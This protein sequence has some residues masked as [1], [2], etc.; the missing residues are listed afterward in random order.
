MKILKISALSIIAII[1][2]SC[3]ASQ[4]T[5]PPSDGS[6]PSLLDVTNILA[7]T[8]SM[9]YAYSDSTNGNI[10]G[11]MVLTSVW[12]QHQPNVESAYLLDSTNLE[13]ILKSGLHA[14]YSLDETDA[15]SLSL[16]RG[17]RGGGGR[18]SA[19]GMPSAHIITNKNVLIYVP[20]YA[21][22]YGSNLQLLQPE[23]KVLQNSDL[24]LNVAVL[25]GSD[26]SFN[27]IAT[28]G[29]YGLVIIDSHGQQGDFQTGTSFVINYPGGPRP[30]TEAD[31]KAIFDAVDPNLYDECVNGLFDIG[32]SAPL[33]AKV[34]NYWLH[35]DNS[36]NDV[37]IWATSKYI[38]TLP[39]MP[40]T[41]IF[42]NMC[43][44][45]S[46]IYSIS[47]LAR[48]V[49]VPWY[50]ST[51]LD[52]EIF[53][54]RTQIF[55]PIAPA[56]EHTSPICYYCWAA[57]DGNTA[58]VDNRTAIPVE[59]SLVTYLVK[60]LDSTGSANLKKADG[61]RFF[62]PY[63]SRWLLNV[64]TDILYL[65][66]L[67]APNYS[68]NDSILDTRDGQSYKIVPIGTQTWM[69]QNLNYNAPG[70]M[71]YDNDPRNGA[72]LGRLYPWYVAMGGAPSDSSNP[73][74]V[75]GVCPKGWHVPSLS[76]W[77]QLF[78][79]TGGITSFSKSGNALESPFRDTSAGGWLPST[80]N[81]TPSNSSGFSA[82]PGGGFF[83]DTTS[84]PLGT[85]TFHFVG[86][87][88]QG[89]FLTSTLVP[90]G[91]VWAGRVNAITFGINGTVSVIQRQ[92]NPDDPIDPYQP[93]MN[94]SCRC[95]KDP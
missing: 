54:A 12:A 6:T 58:S 18:L 64:N 37:L 23:L 21:A 41:V 70:S 16:T 91:Q 24:G 92:G 19:L 40:N 49:I 68:Y 71:C 51:K 39:P 65:Q 35:Y 47:T 61:T 59:D 26:A 56:F 25:K 32:R 10:W 55:D 57:D 62:D 94:A 31:L 2:A 4:P 67:G 60:T 66:C 80:I 17:G 13:I 78:T 8:D 81:F 3:K 46:S 9:F 15:D 36:F 1:F 7:G 27:K 28:F 83:W 30:K 84:P 45:G 74:K 77:N 52:T 75:Q 53:P 95:V 76:E 48:T 93:S 42:G 88:Q 20:P 43:Y 22:F 14:I 82:L 11:S 89:F 90:A 50:N 34:I 86:K 33:N 72:F 87:S 69:A 73:G 44:S 79:A 29:N 5:G 63:A 38:N 85:P